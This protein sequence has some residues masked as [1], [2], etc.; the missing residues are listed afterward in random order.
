MSGTFGGPCRRSAMPFGRCAVRFAV[1]RCRFG[2]PRRP[3]AVPH[4]PF[5]VP[6]SVSAFRGVCLA[7]RR[8]LLASRGSLLAFPPSS[9]A[10]VSGILCVRSRTDRPPLKVGGVNRSLGQAEGVAGQ[11]RYWASGIGCPPT[12]SPPWIGRRGRMMPRLASSSSA[13]SSARSPPSPCNTAR[14]PSWHSYGSTR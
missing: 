12:V 1:S 5:G 3:F 13:L 6:P 14:F 11:A 4:F 2:I 7:F 9:S 10:G 8:A